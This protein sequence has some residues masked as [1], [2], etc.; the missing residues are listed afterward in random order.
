MPAHRPR[1]ELPI[2]D[3]RGR[4]SAG[5]LASPEETA[6]VVA[7]LERFMR[8]TAPFAAPRSQRPDPWRATAVLEGVEREALGD[9]GD[10]WLRSERP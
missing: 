5:T 4:R 10:P 8:A 7:A 6:A 3:R 2:G 1:L 9:L